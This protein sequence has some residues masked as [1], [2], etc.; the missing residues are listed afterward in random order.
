MSAPIVERLRR[1]SA[2]F[3]DEH[4][5]AAMQRPTLLEREAADTIEAMLGA[6]ETIAEAHLGDQ[7]AASP[8]SEYDW[9]CRHVAIIRGIAQRAIEK[10]RS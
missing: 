3:Y 5:G 9:A 1:G 6:L 2:S 4:M 7:P 10:A 8:G